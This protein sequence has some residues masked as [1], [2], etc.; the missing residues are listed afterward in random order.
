MAV[1]TI[2]IAGLLSYVA[3]S[4]CQP[5]VTV[6][7]GT[8]MGKMESFENDF[9][10]M[11]KDIDVYLGIP[12]AEPPVGERR[13]TPP[14]RKEPWNEDEIYNATYIRDICMQVGSEA[15]LFSV[16][17]DCLHL[18]I[19]A[20]NP[21]PS[22]V[23]VMVFIYGGSFN[24]GNGYRG[25]Y[26]GTALTAIGDVIV[27]TIN[28]RLSTFGFLTTGDEASPGNYGM[29]D[30]VEALRW[31][32][33][34]INA[35][36]GDANR[37]T[38]FGESSGSS[39]VSAHL[40][41]PLSEPLFQQA[42]LQSGTSLDDWSIHEDL[43][44]QREIAFKIGEEVGCSAT[45]TQDLI[46]CMRQVDAEVLNQASYQ[47][48]Y[49]AAIC[50][51]NNF[52]VELPRVSAK[53]NNF[54]KCPLITGFNKDEGT[55]FIMYS[56]PSS[57]SSSEA[58]F[59]SKERFETELPGILTAY[60]RYVNDLIEEG[61]KQVYVDW[62]KADDPEANY[63]DEWN[64]I[65]SDYWFSCPQIYEARLHAMSDVNDVY[66][67]FLTHSPSISFYVEPTW[68]GATH[69]EELHFVF[70]YPF[71]P[72]PHLDF[73]Q[74]PAEEM[75]LSY[76]V[77]KYWTNFAKTGNPNK[78]SSSSPPYND[79]RAWPA[80]TLPGLQYKEL[81]VNLTTGR[82]LK[83][84][85]CHFWNEYLEQLTTFT[86]DLDETERQWREE[87][88]AWK[89]ADLEEWRDAFAEYKTEVSNKNRKRRSSRN[90]L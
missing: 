78:E 42:I 20:P 38:I 49:Y 75:N 63:L 14:L 52:I 44:E 50:V 46:A 77:I 15:E 87:F 24:T 71:D 26:D 56:F 1:F 61:F 79:D 23:P 69:G 29:L 68:L 4:H 90:E 45:S 10:G 19:Y 65:L 35:F 57:S 5:M 74:Y 88:N 80:F 25:Y 18:N 48:G 7:Q 30:Q 81:A 2:I 76:Q 66:M 62:S 27:V 22:D 43:E 41:S 51:D 28:Y 36:G 17:E 47:F 64:N 72:S 83:A 82:G 55:Y 53:N 67:F 6:E 85:E 31:I 73:H 3:L 9:L 86:A 70:G 89:Y 84:D 40:F 21:K 33:A 37:I 60:G 54:K 59:V 12:Y 8:L 39:A 32:N 11:N 58:P 34:N 16:S 13:F